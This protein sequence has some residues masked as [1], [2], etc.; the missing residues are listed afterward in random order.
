VASNSTN[1]LLYLVNDTLDF[2]QIKSGKFNSKPGRFNLR[3]LVE[4]S[5]EII[6]MQMSQKGLSKIIE[7][8]P[9]LL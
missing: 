4:N 6:S 2:Y 3:E 8:D 5:F 7:I 9:I 1:L